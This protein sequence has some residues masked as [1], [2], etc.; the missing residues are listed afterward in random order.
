MKTLQTPSQDLNPTSTLVY[1]SQPLTASFK[2]GALYHHPQRQQHK[3]ANCS[4]N[5]VRQNNRQNGCRQKTQ[6]RAGDWICNRCNNH[7][8]S[9]R[10]QCNSCHKQSKTQNLFEL[11]QLQAVHTESDQF[12]LSTAS[13]SQ[14]AQSPVNQQKK[15][16]KL[17]PNN[18]FKPTISKFETS[19][20]ESK[21]NQQSSK[22]SIESLDTYQKVESPAST[23]LDHCP[24]KDP[25]SDVSFDF[26]EGL[27]DL[28][29][30][31]T[32]SSIWLPHEFSPC[33]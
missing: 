31:K 1:F 21:E 14:K 10:E 25:D 4:K 27:I 8:Y 5:N 6:H 29:E 7:N 22:I 16:R 19:F 17:N 15:T 20:L 26:D 24:F 23:K 11:L 13:N 2:E 3:H 32:K 33:R 30:T 18:Y 9:F 12:A 28:S